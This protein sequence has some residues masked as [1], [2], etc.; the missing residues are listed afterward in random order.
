MIGKTI[1]HY[2]ILEELGS[3]GMGVVYKAKDTKLER[4]V[5]LK[6]LPA[7]LTRDPE[8]INRF[9]QEARAASALDHQ[10]ICTIYEINETEDG[11][12]FICMAYYDGDS[13]KQKVEQEPMPVD[14][15][16]EVAVQIAEGLAKAHEQGIVHRDIKPANVMITGDGTVKIVDF[17]LAKLT[18]ATKLT[19]EGTTIGTIDYM[20][21]EQSKGDEVDQRTDIWALG[22]VLYE[23]LTGRGPFRGEY[24]QA[25]IYSILN[26]EPEQVTALR[27]GAPAGI[28]RIIA[29][30]LAK[31]P[32]NR[33]QKISDFLEALRSLEGTAVV[34][35]EDVPSIA[36]LPFVNMSPDPENEYFGDGLA[37]ELIN[38]LA[39]LKGLHVAARTSA[40][41]FR[42]GDTDLREVGERLGVK[43]IFEGSVRRAG[44]KLRITAQLINASDGYH[45]WSER[46]DREM[47]DI[48]VIQD[49]ITAA[50]V[51]ELEIKLLGDEEKQLVKRYT[52]DLDAYTLFLKGRYHWNSLTP[53]GYQKSL[54]CYRK[55]VELDPDYALA[56]VG[57]AIW[58]H[59]HTFWGVIPPIEANEKARGY[60]RKAMS[61]DDKIAIAYNVS[62]T[63]DFGYDWDWQSAERNLKESLELDPTDSLAYINYSLLLALQK[64]Y[65]E[66]ASNM[67]VARRLDPL[68]PLILAW[69]GMIPMLE[70]RIEEAIKIFK[71]AIEI[72]P[73]Y[74]QPYLWLGTSH[75]YEPKLDEA[76]EALV[77]SVEL[78]GGAS[79]TESRLVCAYY[80]AGE[81]EKADKLF[82][83]LK[84]KADLIYIPPSFFCNIHC[85]RGEQGIAIE[86]LDKAV[87]IRD[88][89]L[90]TFDAAPP[91]L[92]PYGPR[93]DEILRIVGIPLGER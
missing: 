9:V 25:V 35:N 93:V 20:S 64:R 36:V 84:E 87:E 14:R 27:D 91:G 92:R 59:S 30:A 57:M 86:W 22:V 47:E 48:F 77:K 58:Y 52:E 85:A 18:D 88:A 8:M 50:I 32:D 19:K 23:M 41:R 42:A 63:L 66:A 82:E 81:A 70:G 13:L 5:A 51:K 16:L 60:V 11:R 79:I 46:Y 43:T 55:A 3:G 61:I 29:K 44:N 67:A 49:E 39:Q 54:E 17:G 24:D 28:D 10:N 65:D 56:Y 53:E 37:E 31:D 40:F 83:E 80:L 76:I 69:A 38:A 78:S 4:F 73:R 33:Y 6:F 75:L 26:E 90:T 2:K 72:D 74:W 12:M 15:A 1:S 62:G 34:Q 71:E 68:A 21:P 89:W 7:E 45:L